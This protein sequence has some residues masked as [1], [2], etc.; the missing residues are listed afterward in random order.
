MKPVRPNPSAHSG[1]TEWLL[2][3]ATALYLAAFLLYLAFRLLTDPPADHEAWRAWFAPGGA[4][5]A[6][7]LAF[8]ALLIHAWIGLRSVYIDYL[9]PLSLRL[10]AYLLTAL[11]LLALALWC[12]QVLLSAGGGA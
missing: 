11:G 6:W 3:R 5:I 12:A 1:L 8:A 7:A 2:Q 10:A 9:R 4:R